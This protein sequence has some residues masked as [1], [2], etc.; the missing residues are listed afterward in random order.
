MTA[1][2]QLR[3]EIAQTKTAID[4]IGSLALND[5]DT[6]TQVDELIRRCQR[7]F[8]IDHLGINLAHPGQMQPGDIASAVFGANTDAERVVCIMAMFAEEKMREL[9]TASAL[10]FADKKATPLSKRN[11]QLMALQQRLLDLEREEEAAF[12]DLEVTGV[13]GIFR[14]PDADMA[15]ILLIDD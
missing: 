10:K 14:R 13:T 4:Q 9:L 2:T 8:D 15:A 3:A 11:D 7:N 6:R 12:L 1:L 5:A